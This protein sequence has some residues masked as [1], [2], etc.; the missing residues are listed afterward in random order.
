[1]NDP[2]IPAALA[3]A[4]VGPAALHNFQPKPAFTGIL[5]PAVQ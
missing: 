4:V 5:S 2:Q 3:L 1:M